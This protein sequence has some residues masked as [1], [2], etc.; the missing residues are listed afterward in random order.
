V[1]DA[2]LSEEQI[3]ATLAAYLGLLQRHVSAEVMMSKILTDDFETGFVGG[4]MWKG[5]DGLRDFLSQREG[6]FD[7]R[8]E[9]KE[10]LEVAPRSDDEVEVKTRLE[11]SSGAGSHRR[12]RATSS[13]AGRFTPGSC[14]D[15]PASPSRASR[16]SSWMDSTTSTTTRSAC[17]R[18]PRRG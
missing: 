12:R 14:A 8:H 5:L 3:R 16:P 1:S 2:P 10:V 11:F 15:P 4:H 9:V 17:S 7:E 6:F 13:P 18:L